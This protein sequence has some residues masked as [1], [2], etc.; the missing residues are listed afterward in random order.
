MLQKQMI[1]ILLASLDTLL[2]VHA[3]VI[4]TVLNTHTH[5]HTFIHMIIKGWIVP[6]VMS[7]IEAW[8]QHQPGMSAKEAWE[9]HG[10]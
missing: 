10:P 9:Q 1:S 8:E 7:I 4:H 5:T 6:F 2:P 3:K